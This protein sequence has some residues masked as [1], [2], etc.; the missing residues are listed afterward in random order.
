MPRA[1][2]LLALAVA[3]AGCAGGRT[4]VPVSMDAAAMAMPQGIRPFSLT[5]CG[6]SALPS[7][8]C[9]RQ[10]CEYKWHCTL[11]SPSA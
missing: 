9:C 5:P 6:N 11:G 7:A 10:W 3:A 1:L 4:V 2:V 8:S